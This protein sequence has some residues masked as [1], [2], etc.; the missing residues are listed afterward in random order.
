MNRDQVFISYSHADGDWLK[1]LQTMLAPLQRQGALDVWADTRIQPGQLWKEEI[2][3]ALARAKVAVLLVSPDFLASEFIARHEFPTL[4]EAAS[5]EGL[6]ILWVPVR[7]SLYEETDIARYQAACDPRTPL[8]TLTAAE[9]DAA[10]VQIAKK[11]RAVKPPVS[12]P[13]IVT[14]K[15]E[16]AIPIPEPVSQPPPMQPASVPTTPIRGSAFR[17][18]I[19]L[20]LGILGGTGLY[21]LGSEFYQ[22]YQAAARRKAEEEAAARRKAEEEAAAKEEVWLKLNEAMS[23]MLQAQQRVVSMPMDFQD[24]LK[25]GSPGPNMVVIPAGTFLMGPP[26]NEKSRKDDER[27]RSVEIKPN[28]AIGKT[29][30]TVGQ[31]RRFVEATSYRTEAE[32]AGGCY[33]WDGK[34]WQQTA[35]KNWRNP[36]FKQDDQHPVVC[37]SWNDALKYTEWL[38]KQTGQKYRLPT[39]AEWEYAARAGTQTAYY[40]GDNPNEGCHFG[41]GADRTV[42]EQF[43][44]WTILECKDGYVYTAPVGRFQTNDFGLYDMLGNV[45]EWTCSEYDKNYGGAELRCVS[46]PNSGGPRVVRGGSWYFGPE[47]LRSAAR[48]WFN[49]R[50][51]NFNVGFRLARTLTL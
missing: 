30:V 16:P 36:G 31:F 21:Y 45:W 43:P 18:L 33:S 48:G 28:F 51:W 17:L 10:L 26:E 47:W 49:S 39:E 40:W 6:I 23:E 46:D 29:E 37:V 22:T 7:H 38:S 20:M 1:R 34:A 25:D 9:Q 19:I 13:L 14:P 24:T 8:S 44:G 3:K 41:N 50:D 35:D 4:L 2:E 27:Q 42:K 5:K 32:T 15:A 11:L 12:P